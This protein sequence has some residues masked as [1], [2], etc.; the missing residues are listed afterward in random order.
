ML[1]VE[2]DMGWHAGYDRPPATAQPSTFTFGFNIKTD[3]AAAAQ[4]IEA[5]PVS[6]PEDLTEVVHTPPAKKQKKGKDQQKT[7]NRQAI[8]PAANAPVL[9]LR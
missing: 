6:M 5:E 3:A 1:A 4:T 9:N 8:L 7:D 2:N